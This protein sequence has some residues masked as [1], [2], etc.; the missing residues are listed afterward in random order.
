MYNEVEIEINQF[1]THIHISKNKIQKISGNSIYS[2]MHPM[3]RSK[4]F[5]MMHDFLLQYIPDGYNVLTPISLDIKFYVP[6]NYGDVRFIKKNNAVSWKVPPADYVPRWDIDNLAW[7]WNKA[8][9]DVLV[10]KFIIEDDTVEQV[11]SV[12][13]HFFPCETLEE[14]KIVINIQTLNVLD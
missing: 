12:R 5:H 2:G 11:Q 14:R 10:K 3:V 4:L 7:P 9:L 13:Y 8:I 1:P 6:I